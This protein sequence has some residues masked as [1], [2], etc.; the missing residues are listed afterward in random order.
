MHQTDISCDCQSMI[1]HSKP[2]SS[3]WLQ[4]IESW[5]DA[6]NGNV[7]TDEDTHGLLPAQ[8]WQDILQRHLKLHI[9]ISRTL[10]FTMGII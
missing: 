10:F 8:V 2:L 3:V 7:S 9:S 6:H 1:C 5:L 4:I